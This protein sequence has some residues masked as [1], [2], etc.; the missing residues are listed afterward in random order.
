VPGARLPHVWVGDAATTLSTHDLARYGRFTLFT[1]ISGDPWAA[2]AQ[3]TA[4]RLGVPL[5]AV[6]IGPGREVTD[7]YFDWAAGREVQE[8]GA[9][10]V[11]PD[12]HVCWRSHRLV[13][14][15]AAVLTEVLAGILNCGGEA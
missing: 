11:R 13:D 12:K 6:V 5:D 14:D 1:G 9:V 4:E 15:P 2:A 10:L 8:D 7:L 3:E